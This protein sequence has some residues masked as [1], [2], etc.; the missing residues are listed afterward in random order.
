MEDEQIKTVNLKSNRYLTKRLIPLF[1]LL[2]LLMLLAAVGI[3]LCIYKDYKVVLYALS[4]GASVLGLLAIIVAVIL[5]KRYGKDLSKSFTMM[6]K[7]LAD[8]AKGDIKLSPA[9]H[10]LPT[11]ER[12][13]ESINKAIASY[14]SYRLVY[15]AQSADNDLKQKI[16]AGQVFAYEEF[17]NH[18]YKEVQ[19][20]LSFRSA[21]LL[22]QIEGSEPISAQAFKDLHEQILKTFPGSIVGLHDKNTY[23]VYV[24]AVESFLSLQNICEQFVTSFKSYELSNYDDVSRVNYCK[25]GGVV[26]PYTPATNLLSEAEAALAKSKDVLINTGMK[27]VYF[28]HAIVSESNRRIIYL[29]SIES[30]QDNFRK[31]QNYA[32]Q[33][34]AVKE[35]IRWF[36]VTT[37]FEVGGVLTYNSKTND[38]RLIVETGKTPVEK[39]FSRLGERFPGKDIDPFYD[40]SMNDLSFSAADTKDL[41]A[42]M[43]TYL[44][45]LGVESC[46]FSAITFYGE[47]RGLLYLTSSKKRP[48]FSLVSREDMNGYAAII[49]SL[50]V[51]IQ[52]VT[53]SEE[54]TGLLESL[55]ARTNKYLYSIDRESYKLTYLSANLQKAFPGAHVG[56][57]CWKVLRTAHTEPC[58]HCP[59][60][61]GV[62]HRIIKSI[63]STESTVSL[64]QSRGAEEDI[65]TILIEKSETALEAGEA[66]SRMMDPLLLIKNAQALSIEVSRQIKSG[67]VGY[68]VSAKFL[69]AEKLIAQLPGSDATS[70][71]ISIVKALQDIGYGDILYRYDTFELSFLLTS[72]TKVK[73]TDFVEEIASVLSESMSVKDVTFKPRFAYSAI[74]YPTDAD[75]SRGMMSLIA[76]ELDRSETFGDGY[77]VEVENRHPRKALRTDYIMDLLQTAITADDMPVETQPILSVKDGHVVGGDILARLYDDSGTAIAPSEFMPLAKS[78]NLLLKVNMGGLRAA[79]K[80]YEAYGATYFHSCNLEHLSVYLSL[81]AIQSPDFLTTMKNILN[82]YR[83]PKNFLV[84]AFSANDFKKGEGYLS[85]TINSLA[86]YGLLYEVCNYDIDTLALEDLRRLGIERIKVSRGMVAQAATTE[87]DYASFSRFADSAMR[88]GFTVTVVG[89]ETKEEL[90]LLS[91]LEVPYCQGYYFAKPLPEKD[92]IQYLNYGKK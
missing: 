43:A 88:A 61:A 62:D 53:S 21:L 20:N 17:Q 72:Y 28:P 3:P 71:M 73:I 83:F 38:Y 26:Y 44:G 6:D 64:L 45:N 92:F 81:E 2:G 5:V 59:L 69:D 55:S 66:S 12:L 91:H 47:K 79:G 36:A 78:K 1:I 63:A 4:I 24:Y 39:S 31:A 27:S 77:L 67:L 60:K 34:T 15:M 9:H 46:F 25:L 87:S 37:D 41:P 86:S 16:E 85:N 65:S 54:A 75:N 51:S 22:I 11:I 8:F 50:L 68:V 84:L 7:Q 74:A 42:N 76:K 32:E 29:A 49:T 18:L 14:S 82:R 58:S 90:D 30:F 19:N 40:A 89:V 33:V 56:D 23:I 35:F 13:Q 48:Y 70:L 10:A 57:V 52:S 80:L